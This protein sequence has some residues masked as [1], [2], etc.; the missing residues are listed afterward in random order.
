[1]AEGDDKPTILPEFV[2]D[3][4]RAVHRL[5]PLVE[6][7]AAVRQ[8]EPEIARAGLDFLQRLKREDRL[9]REQ[10][11][12]LSATANP[13]PPSA[14]KTSISVPPANLAIPIPPVRRRAKRGEQRPR[15]LRALRK[16]CPPFGL[17]PPGFDREATTEK[18]IFVL[19]EEKATD[20]RRRRRSI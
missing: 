14:T 13:D 2:A 19:D 4:L 9:K 5:H 15:I 17:P 10:A 1:M 7:I 16:V 18:V 20:R 11:D 8:R 6:K 3:V 12:P